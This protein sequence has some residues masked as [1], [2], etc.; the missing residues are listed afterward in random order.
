MAKQKTTNIVGR[1]IT[2]VKSILTQVNKN[3][4]AIKA[5]PTGGGSGG[6]VSWKDITS[7]YKTTPPKAGSF[8]RITID[9]HTMIGVYESGKLTEQLLM[10]VLPPKWSVVER[11]WT[12]GHSDITLKM[13]NVTDGSSL[14]A[15]RTVPISKFE[16]LE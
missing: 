7:T 1:L 9:G 12:P 13:W 10:Q 11:T 15:E 14:G 2:K 3:T 8:C 6:G 16:V 4:A 5:L